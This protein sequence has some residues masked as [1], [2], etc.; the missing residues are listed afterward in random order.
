MKWPINYSEDWKKNSDLAKN[1]PAGTLKQTQRF[2]LPWEITAG[3]ADWWVKRQKQGNNTLFPP[4]VEMQEKN[5]WGYQ[6]FEKQKKKKRKFTLTFQKLS[7]DL[8]LSLSGWCSLVVWWSTPVSRRLSATTFTSCVLVNNRSGPILAS[9]CLF[10]GEVC[11]P[12]KCGENLTSFL[13]ESGSPVGGGVRNSI[14]GK[15]QG[16]FC[17]VS[18]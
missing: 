5:K 9:R 16:A 13:G 17:S 4:N 15:C 3:Q 14:V 18:D 7:L 8:S 2:Q 6:D 10:V 1:G 11:V 12:T